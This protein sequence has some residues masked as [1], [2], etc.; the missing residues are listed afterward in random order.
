MGQLMHLLDPPAKPLR[1]A[2]QLYRK[3]DGVHSTGMP[4]FLCS[5]TLSTGGDWY[6]TCVPAAGAVAVDSTQCTQHVLSIDAQGV[7]MYLV[8]LPQLQQLLVVALCLATLLGVGVGRLRGHLQQ[9]CQQPL[10]PLLPSSPCSLT[11]KQ[12]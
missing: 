9:A 6:A 11:A 5:A 3:A 10:S 12:L 4:P 2:T 8:G 7:S 1:T